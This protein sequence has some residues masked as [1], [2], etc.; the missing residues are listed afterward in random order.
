[1]RVGLSTTTLEPVL[2]AGRHD[3][4][5]VYTRGLCEHLPAAG[6]DVLPFSFA[7][8]GAPGRVSVG[9]ALPLS[10]ALATLGDVLLPASACL[11]VS[12][13]LAAPLDLFH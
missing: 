2:T 8:P 11:H 9:R 7:P 5:A 3:G 4:L 12:R 6:V 1:M 10:F 13:T